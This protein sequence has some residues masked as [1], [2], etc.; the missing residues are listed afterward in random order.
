MK[1]KVFPPM[2]QLHKNGS[3]QS[4]QIC[5]INKEFLVNIR[6][7]LHTLGIDSKVTFNTNSTQRLLPDG[8]G[9][10]KLFNC[11]ESFRLLISSSGLYKLSK[12]GFKPKD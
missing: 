8:K 7:M 3:N 10:N 12:L 6:L 2:E 1:N 11:K 5:S 9:G 4:I